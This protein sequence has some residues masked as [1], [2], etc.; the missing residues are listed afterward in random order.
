MIKAT[1]PGGHSFEVSHADSIG[2]RSD[3]R[4]ALAKWLAVISELAPSE[5][6]E[7]PHPPF[8][9]TEHRDTTEQETGADAIRQERLRQVS[10]EGWTPE[11]DDSHNDGSLSV[12]AAILAVAGT[13]AKVV[14]TLDRVRDDGRDCWGLLDKHHR[15]PVRCLTIAGAMIAAEIDRISRQ[16]GRFEDTTEQ[17]GE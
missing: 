8:H 9:L 16:A 2:G 6:E 12:V 13:D 4:I 1:A 3:E 15:D 14:D 17:E 11:H 5:A 10:E 7:T